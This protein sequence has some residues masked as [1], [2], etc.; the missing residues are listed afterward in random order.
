MTDSSLDT[1]TLLTPPVSLEHENLLRWRIPHE[2]AHSLSSSNTANLCHAQE[3][4]TA[5]DNAASPQSSENTP[6]G[7]ARSGSTPKKRLHLSSLTPAHKSSGSLSSTPTKAKVLS[8]IKSYSTLPTASPG[9]SSANSSDAATANVSPSHNRAL[10]HKS[11]NS[12]LNSVPSTSNF[13]TIYRRS[14]APVNLTEANKATSIEETSNEPAS[15]AQPSALPKSAS[16]EQSSIID[17]STNNSNKS[18]RNSGGNSDRISNMGSNNTAQSSSPQQPPQMP[19]VPVPSSFLS[20]SRVSQG[21]PLHFLTP[22]HAHPLIPVQALIPYNSSPQALGI[23]QF[24][25]RFGGFL[26]ENLQRTLRELQ[27]LT[28]SHWNDGGSSSGVITPVPIGSNE[29]L[30][31]QQVLLTLIKNT[32]TFKQM[33]NPIKKGA[34]NAVLAGNSQRRS[35]KQQNL[36]VSANNST[37]TARSTATIAGKHNSS[38]SARSVLTRREQN[39][40]EPALTTS[41]TKE[42]KGKSVGNTATAAKS[43]QSK[44]NLALSEQNNEGLS[45]G[46]AQNSKNQA[47]IGQICENQ[48]PQPPE[49]NLD[50]QSGSLQSAFSASPQPILPPYGP[51]FAAPPYNYYYPAPPFPAPYFASPP[52]PQPKSEAERMNAYNQFLWAQQQQQ[53]QFYAQQQIQFAQ[54]QAV[55]AAHQN[56]AQNQ[57]EILNNSSGEM[58]ESVA[59]SSGGAGEPNNHNPNHSVDTAGNSAILTDIEATSPREDS[60]GEFPLESLVTARGG[61]AISI[62]SPLSANNSLGSALENVPSPL[63]IRFSSPERL[64]KFHNL[65]LSEAK[66]ELELKQQKAAK[67]REIEAERRAE[68]AKQAAHRQEEIEQRVSQRIAA[69]SAEIG[70]KL[71]AAAAKHEEFVEEIRRKAELEIQKVKEIAFITAEATETTNY[72]LRRKIEES[73]QRRNL[74]LNAKL[75]SATAVSAKQEAAN[76]KRIK[77]MEVKMKSHANI[78]QK[79]AQAQQRRTQNKKLVNSQQSTPS[80]KENS[81][82]GSSSNSA[83]PLNSNGAAASAA[84]E[85]KPTATARASYIS[86]VAAAA[87]NKATVSNAASPKT[88]SGVNSAQKSVELAGK[89]AQ[90]SK[91]AA[92]NSNN[93]NSNSH[94][95]SMGNNVGAE[96]VS[97]GFATSESPPS[98]GAYCRLCLIEL[99]SA[100]K[101]LLLN[102]VK[103]SL[104]IYNSANPTHAHKNNIILNKALQQYLNGATVLLGPDVVQF[105]APANLAEILSAR[106]QNPENS[107]QLADS[108]VNSLRMESPSKCSRR[109]KKKKARKLKQQIAANLSSADSTE[110]SW[111]SAVSEQLESWGDN[112]TEIKAWI[113]DILG[114]FKALEVLD[115]QGEGQDHFSGQS[116]GEIFSN[117]SNSFVVLT[118]KLNS[119]RNL[120]SSEV[121]FSPSAAKCLAALLELCFSVILDKFQPSSAVFNANSLENLANFPHSYSD[122]MGTLLDCT[123]QSYEN[124]ELFSALVER[125]F[126][127]SSIFVQIINWLNRALAVAASKGLLKLNY[128]INSQFTGLLGKSL[129]V[130]ATGLSLSR[131]ENSLLSQNFTVSLQFC[132]YIAASSLFWRLDQI[133]QANIAAL[134]QLIALYTTRFPAKSA[135]L[136]SPPAKIEQIPTTT[137][138]S[139]ANGGKPAGKMQN[140]GNGREKGAVPEV[141]SKIAEPLAEF[142]FPFYAI[143]RFVHSVVQL[144]GHGN[145]SGPNSD[146]NKTAQQLTQ[147]LGDTSFSGLLTLLSLLTGSG[148]IPRSSVGFRSK[149]LHFQH[150]LHIFRVFNAVSKLDQRFMQNF[151]QLNQKIMNSALFSTVLQLITASNQGAESPGEEICNSFMVENT[152]NQLI[153]PRLNAT[154]L[155]ACCFYEILVFL[156]KITSNCAENQVLMRVGGNSVLKVLA[157]LPSPFFSHAGTRDLLL[158]ALVSLTFPAESALSDPS[159]AKILKGQGK[160]EPILDFLGKFGAQI[161]PNGSRSVSP[162]PNLGGNATVWGQGMPLSLFNLTRTVSSGS[163]SG[164]NYNHHSNQGNSQGNNNSNNRKVA[165]HYSALLPEVAICDL[166]KFYQA[167]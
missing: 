94:N 112:N 127:E 124:S 13:S 75:L 101:E 22:A 151:T 51:Y 118:S 110:N 91:E 77:A 23:W 53:Q 147:A 30:L 149:S 129:D 131:A 144:L 43:K 84:I 119:F 142:P 68:K 72:L 54:Q 83:P 161:G 148:Q 111:T 160:I 121:K 146:G 106:A 24:D 56:S 125:F 120:L 58:N 135:K 122:F 32:A 155:L 123:L 38:A 25:Q 140:C 82:A 5:L 114:D 92:N 17:N 97:A 42:K 80:N 10:S 157:S 64:G 61:V 15:A 81:A 113:L 102:H 152:A 29:E 138:K 96:K 40:R 115:N 150:I 105:K 69:K 11:I 162:V 99:A 1:N 65:T 132:R 166:I 18:G 143:I 9:N 4:S 85:T 21:A 76:S 27:I 133:I 44:S 136:A 95:K 117:H 52:Q 164:T 100:D 141:E 36:K 41:S 98:D 16:I 88:N 50:Q 126:Y 74:A 153:Y 20:S 109:N 37:L 31:V 87:K 116:S 103:S 128:C 79:L 86:I 107:L 39:R 55:A 14:S 159:G 70:E 89:V 47:E 60:L 156:S 26:Y 12:A 8:K 46:A 158:P 19:S 134:G 78:D 33:L 71:G 93:N 137:G 167:L 7:V 59:S 6:R 49:S 45:D 28:Q 108:L 3:N 2:P 163:N 90:N 165:S 130:L 34:N 154:S 48:L 62:P 63:H 66:A 139:A 57:Q 35:N 104:H 73:E 67:K 145:N